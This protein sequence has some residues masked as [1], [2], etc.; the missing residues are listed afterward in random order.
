MGIDVNEVPAPYLLSYPCVSGLLTPC[1]FS[2]ETVK[3]Q[4]LLTLHWHAECQQYL[5]AEMFNCIKAMFARHCMAGILKTQYPSMEQV[6][7]LPVCV[8][9]CPYLSARA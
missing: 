7:T 3:V 1:L 2:Q 5:T 4:K 9:P 6:W 8:L